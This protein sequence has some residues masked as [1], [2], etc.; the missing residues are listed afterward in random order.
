MAS[1]LRR[2]SIV[3][4]VAC[5]RLAFVLT[6]CGAASYTTAANSPHA[7]AS[8]AVPQVAPLSAHGAP[9]K[10]LTGRVLAQVNVVCSAV[11]QGT[12]AILSATPK[13]DALRH[14]ATSARIV[15]QRTIISLQRLAAQ[16]RTSLSPLIAGY[17]QLLGVYAASAAN[18]RTP[19][20]VAAV[21]A[22]AIRQREQAIRS[23]A[24]AMAAPACGVVGR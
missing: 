2:R 13:P 4:A 17:Q 16:R 15:T 23:T 19:T 12:P 20:H 1:A 11:R 14:Y 9:I 6:G 18:A 8:A 10:P 24:R 22:T 7:S 21:E 5:A 3:G